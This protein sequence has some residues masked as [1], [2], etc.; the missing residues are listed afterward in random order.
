MAENRAKNTSQSN[1]NMQNIIQRDARRRMEQMQQKVPYR[2]KGNMQPFYRNNNSAY[3]NSTYKNADTD[4]NNPTETPVNNNSNESSTSEGSKMPF[5]ILN[6]L[7]KYIEK[8]DTDK[9]LIIAMLAIIYKDGGNKK[10]MMALAY[11]L[12]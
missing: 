7:E 2:R 9:I 5:G 1:D 3:N 6:G 11:L 12:T 10:L 8:L 4:R